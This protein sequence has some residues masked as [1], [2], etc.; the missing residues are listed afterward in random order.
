MPGRGTRPRLT[1]SRVDELVHSHRDPDQ[2]ATIRLGSG[3]GQQ[4]RRQL[5]KPDGVS[6]SRADRC[7]Q[8]GDA[9][10]RIIGEFQLPL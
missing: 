8:V 5:A 6:V 4:R 3:Q 10:I 7:P 2:G 1:D 9:R